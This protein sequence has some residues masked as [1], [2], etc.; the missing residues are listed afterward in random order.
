MVVD[1]HKKIADGRN[2][3]GAAMS[4]PH[5]GMQ[6]LLLP[7]CAAVVA[8]LVLMFV[9][10]AMLREFGTTF[11]LGAV[12]GVVSVFWFAVTSLR[13]LASGAIPA[14]PGAWG[15]KTNATNN[16]VGAKES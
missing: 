9:P 12:S 5:D 8:C 6:R 3:R 1:F 15:A 2:V 11:V 14:D 13:L 10:V 16:A 7:T 4:A